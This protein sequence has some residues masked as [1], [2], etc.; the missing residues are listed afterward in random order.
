MPRRRNVPWIH[1]WSRVLIGAIAIAGA[2]ATAYLTVT[3]FGG[4]SVACPT[5]GCDKV[6]SSPYA[7]LGKDGIPLALLGAIAYSGMA[8]LSLGPLA[9]NGGHQKELRKKL[10]DWSWLLLLVGAVSMAIFSGYLMYLLAFVIG[11]GVCIYC[12]VSALFTVSMFILTLIGREWP[13]LGQVLFTGGIVAVVAIIGSVLAYQIS[14][15]EVKPDKVAAGFNI[16]NTSGAAE[17]ALAEQLTKVDAK[18]Y[19]ASWCPHCHDQKELFGKEAVQKFN[20]VECD[21]D[22]DRIISKECQA[23]KIE[24]FPTWKIKDKTVS[25][26]QSLPALA[27]LSGYTGKQDFKNKPSGPVAPPAP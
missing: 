26:T 6:L 12:V 15:G 16:A 2:I 22:G 24:G 13:D 4:Q 17:I 14:S 19:G 3:H 20:Y 1:R 7:R 11:G 23:A 21:P 5:G 8:V 9:V 25:G 18:M 27:K 10:E